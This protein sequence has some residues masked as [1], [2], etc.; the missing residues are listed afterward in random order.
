MLTE[1]IFDTG[2][3]QLNY[4]VGPRNGPPLL[5]LH[6]ITA[7]WQSFS[8]I[9]PGL[10][11]NYQLVAMD[12][13]GHGRSGKLKQGYRLVD[14]SRDVLH[15]V[16]ALL[17]R[18]AF[19]L[20][21]S[22]GALAAIYVAARLPQEILAIILLDPPLIYRK[23]PLKDA[24]DSID[25]GAYRGFVTMYEIMISSA[26]RAEIEKQLR[27]IYP[28]WT[29]EG[30]HNLAQ[31]LNNMDAEVVGVLLK[32]Q[33]ME[34]YDTDELL[35]QVD[36]PV[37]IIQGNRR[38]GAALTDDDAAYLLANLAQCRVVRIEEAGHNVH[39]IQPDKVTKE[40]IDFLESI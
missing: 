29:E 22:F 27:S 33:H 11:Q 4:A 26:S 7:N 32:H 8:S 16:Q 18:P 9:I 25:Q 20:G 40:V 21:H 38:Q 39:V 36:C 12:L 19:I 31:R 2:E 30:Y 3:I 24:P 34:N 10:S 35:K 13:R 23:M 28:D 14:Y 37:L 6:G 17:K 1:G 5:L 15:F